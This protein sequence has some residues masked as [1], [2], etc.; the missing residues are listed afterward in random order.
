MIASHQEVEGE[1]DVNQKQNNAFNSRN[2][3]NAARNG[4]WVVMLMRYV[5]QHS[6][7]HSGALAAGG[8]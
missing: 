6:R 2:Q 7:I 4:A 3:R 1:L 8:R 5:D